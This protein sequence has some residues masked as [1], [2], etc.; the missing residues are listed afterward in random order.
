MCLSPLRI[1]NP[2][3][4]MRNKGFGFMKD[5]VT[6][7]INVPCGHCK[8]CIARRQMEFVQRVQMEAL[9][10]YL[11][12]C[13]ITY[14]NDSLPYLDLSN[15]HRVRYADVDDVQKMIKRLRRHNA[16]GRDFR[17]FA[18]SELGEEKGRPHFHIIFALPKREDD[19][20]V[21]PLQL[22]GVMFNEVL[23][24]WR[25]N[26]A[27]RWSKK[28]G[29]FIPD[30]FHPDFR[31]CCT[32]V[33]KMIRGQI[34]TN[35]DLHYINPK[36]S[37]GGEADVAFYVLKY[38]LKPSDREV[39]LQRAL[40][41]NLPEEEYEAVWSMVKC[42]HFESECF[43]LGQAVYPLLP[44]GCPD[45]KHPIIHP[46][47]LAHLSRGIALSKETSAFPQYFNPLNGKS[48]PLARYYYRFP[49]IYSVL[50]ALD[51]HF[52]PFNKADKDNVVIREEK[53]L[54]QLVKT[55]DDFQKS[56]E[57]VFSRESASNLNELFDY[58]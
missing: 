36:L 19:T 14:N 39:R 1:R 29:R 40:R 33:R 43:G 18:V 51:F 10:N 32:Y 58:E 54:S 7:Y 25:R 12:Y 4:G 47:V 30:S 2:N 45:K 22:E 38:M 42:R 35:Y 34:R 21:T 26:Y 41:L 23:K 8:E 6:Q 57:I 16:F 44:D 48:F 20:D 31:P 27:V 13:T 11:F 55:M 3:S 50:D 15:G 37:D 5:C 17:F 28:K 46:K 52:S 56:L 9:V 49:E 53:H 24:E